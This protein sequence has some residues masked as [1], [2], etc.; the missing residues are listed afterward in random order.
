VIKG[1]TDRDGDVSLDTLAK[2]LASA[3]DRAGRA[4]KGG[5]ADAALAEAIRARRTLPSPEQIKALGAESGSKGETLAKQIE[6]MRAKLDAALERLEK[7]G[8][9]DAPGS[10][11]T[12]D[13]VIE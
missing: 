6:A 8:A 3:I 11:M 5:D 12:Q 1:T 4:F 9:G 10:V 2:S 7:A 13:L